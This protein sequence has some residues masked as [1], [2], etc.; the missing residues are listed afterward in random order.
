MSHSRYV[1]CASS[2]CEYLIL[3]IAKKIYEVSWGISLIEAE[4]HVIYDAE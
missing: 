4:L 3:K 1:N 2:K